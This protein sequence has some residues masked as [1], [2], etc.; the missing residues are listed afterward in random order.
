MEYETN[1]FIY[2][3]YR[4]SR[5]T[6]QRAIPA[7]SLPMAM[8]KKFCTI[9]LL[10]TVLTGCARYDAAMA[11]Q[12]EAGGQPN[13][14]TNAFGAIGGIANSQTPEMQA[15]AKSVDDCMARYDQAQTQ[16]TQ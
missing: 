8:T 9:L 14:W 13:Q 16:V 15:Y 6:R 4:V 10:L 3:M 12:N 5:G 2:C 1:T 11:C 7:S